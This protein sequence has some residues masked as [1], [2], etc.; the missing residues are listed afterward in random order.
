M[1]V[2]AK[3]LNASACIASVTLMTAGRADDGPDPCHLFQAETAFVTQILYMQMEDVR[4]TLTIPEVYFE[5]AFDRVDGVEHRAQLFRVLIEDFTPVTRRDTADLFRNGR[6]E[7]VDFVL[8]D[9]IDLDGILPISAERMTTGDGRDMSVYEEV[10]FDFGLLAVVPRSGAQKYSE[11]YVARNEDGA[12]QAV[13]SCS[14]NPTFVHWSCNHD[15]RAHEIDVGMSY[16]RVDLRDWQQI[17]TSVSRFISC[18]LT[19]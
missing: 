12:L 19:H 13:I 11:T 6:K 2:R 5:D 10:D 9:P 8:Q 16:S 17:Q 14:N 7:Y 15:F 18:A 4:H 3:H 1:T